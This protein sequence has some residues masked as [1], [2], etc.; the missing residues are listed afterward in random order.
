MAP[1]EKG[2]ESDEVVEQVNRDL[3][4]ETA[5]FNCRSAGSAKTAP[6]MW[7]PALI[8]KSGS[9]ATTGSINL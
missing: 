1:A 6:S 9:S 2:V 8:M 3:A 4:F 5:L 7:S